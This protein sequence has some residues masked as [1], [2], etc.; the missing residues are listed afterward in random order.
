MRLHTQPW[1]E[2]WYDV[3]D[4]IGLLIVEEC[5]VWC[6]PYAYRLSDPAFWTNYSQHITAAVKRDWNHPSI[7]L[8][9]LEN[10]ILSC[11]GDRIFAAT[12][13]QLASMGRLVK[14]LD[15]T[16][17]ITYESDLDPGGEADVLGLHYPHE[18]PDYQCWPNSA[19]WM[20]QPIPR[21]WMPGGQWTWDHAKPLYIGEFLFMPSTSAGGFTILYGD[22]AYQDPQGYRDAAKG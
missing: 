16:R 5:A 22:D 8:W 2:S 11:G 17:P 21:S 14:S 9:S 19:W 20:N 12:P 15:P 13:N 6:D 7:V 1:D 4:Q 10:E 3:A 18:F